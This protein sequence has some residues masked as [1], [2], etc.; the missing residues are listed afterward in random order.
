M[1]RRASDVGSRAW[2]AWAA[3]AVASCL[4]ASVA[5]ARTVTPVKVEDVLRVL[6]AY[7]DP[8]L[9]ELSK[10]GSDVDLVLADLMGNPKQ[11]VEIRMRAAA[12]LGLFEGSRPEAVL[13]STLSSRE[14]PSRVRAAAMLGL[15]RKLG[16]GVVEDLR[17][18]LRDADATLR[19]GA[20]RALGEAGGARAR[21]ILTDG[22]ESEDSLDVRAAIEAALKR[23]SSGQ[24]P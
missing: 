3:I 6:K 18:Y 5:T 17:T 8:G 22:L 23:A 13:T 11:D 1:R 14:V 16:Q 21:G 24:K 9:K 4:W 7:P 20:A 2:G 15:A 10:A 19:M 12:A